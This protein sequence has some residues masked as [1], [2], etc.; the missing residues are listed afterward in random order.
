MKKKLQKNKKNNLIFFL[1][2][3]LTVFVL[4]LTIG[5]SAA[6]STLA[7][8]GSALVRSSADVRITNIQRVQAGN[9]VTLKYL[10]LDS[11]QTFTIDC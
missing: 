2:S 6:S 11:N 1:F 3:I 8:N 10:S 7:I 9:D 4:T 5:F